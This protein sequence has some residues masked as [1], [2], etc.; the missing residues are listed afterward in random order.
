[1]LDLE[2]IDKDLYRSKK[3]W[4]PTG[5][6]GVFGKTRTS[7][8]RLYNMVI[9]QLRLVTYVRIDDC[10]C[11]NSPWD[12][13]ISLRWQCSRTGL[14][15]CHQHGLTTV[16]GSCESTGA[17]TMAFGE[18]I[19]NVVTCPLNISFFCRYCLSCHIVLYSRYTLIF[20]CPVTTL[21]QLYTWWIVS[22]MV[23]NAREKGNDKK[24]SN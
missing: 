17:Y 8:Y 14:G 15:R 12:K 6:R 19:D 16:L 5:A 22:E 23:N 9:I 11:N 18:R 1:M 20:C 24:K 13:S 3:L 7:H 10:L 4:L 21:S 2:E